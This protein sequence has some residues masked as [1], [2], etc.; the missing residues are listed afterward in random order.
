VVYYDFILW[1]FL[2][3]YRVV[4]YSCCPDNLY[5]VN[6]EERSLVWEVTI[7]VIVKKVHMNMSLVLKG[8]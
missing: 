4:G 7:L 5:R 2:Y 3:H 8:Y 6:Q 1:I